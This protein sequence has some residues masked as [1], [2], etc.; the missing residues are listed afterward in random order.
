MV[1]KGSAEERER[2]GNGISLLDKRLSKTTP[3]PRK[4]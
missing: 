2:S 1:A 4:S 3:S